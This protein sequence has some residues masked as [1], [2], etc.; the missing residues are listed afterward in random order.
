MTRARSSIF[1]DILYAQCWE[2]PDIDRSAF[3]A[4]PSDTIFSITSG[5]CNTLAFL[6]DDPKTIY[7]LDMNPSQNHLLDFKMAAFAGLSYDCML[8]LLG[9]RESRRRAELYDAIRP[10]LGIPGRAYW[11]GETARIAGG[12][13]H[14]G[15]YERYM[16]LL[17]TWLR[18]VKGRALLE[19][20]FA[21][22]GEEEREE[23]YRTRWDTPA[24]RLF[25]RIFLSRRMMSALFTDDFFRYVEG[26]FSFGDHFAAR[27]RGALTSSSFRE[28][29][30]A[31]YILLGGYPHGEKPPG[32][33]PEGELRPD[34]GPS[35]PGGDGDGV[36]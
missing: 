17:R 26:S 36:V 18:V 32:L 14:S 34:P 25:T 1:A 13:I 8:E 4:G 28:N 11:D 20:F 7:A 16:K 15:R 35:R 2:D 12:V 23:L 24:W 3:A 22:R 9:V 30:F 19:A 31:A 27:V 29:S 6:V 10:F 33:P 5:G 21:A